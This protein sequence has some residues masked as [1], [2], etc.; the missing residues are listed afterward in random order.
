MVGIVTSGISSHLKWWELK[1]TKQ[2]NKEYMVT[3]KFHHL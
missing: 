1:Q 2:N 3:E